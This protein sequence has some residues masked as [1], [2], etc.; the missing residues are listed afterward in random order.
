MGGHGNIISSVLSMF[1]VPDPIYRAAV[2]KANKQGMFLRQRSHHVAKAR[3]NSQSSHL[4][5]AMDQRCLRP[6]LA[7][8]K[9]TNKQTIRLPS[10]SKKKFRDLLLRYP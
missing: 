10:F 6:H 8:N 7:K 1:R 3:L 5:S 9:Q 4:R 2:E